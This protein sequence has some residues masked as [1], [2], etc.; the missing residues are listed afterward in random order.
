MAPNLVC[1]TIG[2]IMS[3]YQSIFDFMFSFISFLGISSPGIKSTF[4]SLLG[5][6]V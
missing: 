4:D 5:C 2:P 6:S 1:S 3:V